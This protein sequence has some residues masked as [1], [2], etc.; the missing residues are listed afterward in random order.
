MKAKE[1]SA[2]SPKYCLSSKQIIEAMPYANRANNFIPL[3]KLHKMYPDLNFWNMDKPTN[4][5]MSEY[6]K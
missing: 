3:I 1:K 5:E 6:P 2:D 4:K